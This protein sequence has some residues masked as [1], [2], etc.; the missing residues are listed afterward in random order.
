MGEQELLDVFDEN[1]A[2][3]GRATRDEVH[4]NGYCTSLS[5]AGWCGASTETVRPLSATRPQKK[6]YPN[7]LDITAAGHLLAGESPPDGCA[8]SMRS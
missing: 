1:M 8:S 4:E 7:T 3:L 5:T 2:Y 6:L